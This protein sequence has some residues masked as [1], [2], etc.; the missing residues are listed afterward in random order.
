ML[1]DMNIIEAKE[2]LLNI[3][4]DELC[5]WK[6]FRYEEGNWN[7]AYEKRNTIFNN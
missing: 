7:F 3:L 6:N 4:K 1:K 2:K 5:I